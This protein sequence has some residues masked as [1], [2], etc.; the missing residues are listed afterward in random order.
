MLSDSRSTERTEAIISAFVQAGR[1]LE[2]ASKLALQLAFRKTCGR[3][4]SYDS[5]LGLDRG[6]EITYKSAEKSQK[7]H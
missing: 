1:I 2:I 6:H 7:T 4:S 3:P 5:Q